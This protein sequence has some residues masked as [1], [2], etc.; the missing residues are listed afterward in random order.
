MNTGL[1]VLLGL[2]PAWA[3]A[4]LELLPDDQLQTVFSSEA[5]RARVVFRNSGP[6]PIEVC[7]RT[8][9]FQASSTTLMPLDEAQ[10]WKTIRLL[11]EQTV[12]EHITVTLPAVRARTL[13]HVQWLD[14]KNAVLGRTILAAYPNDL[15]KPLKG[16]A[17]EKRLGVLDMDEQLIPALKRAGVEFTDLRSGP[18]LDGFEGGVAIIF[19]KGVADLPA[20]I[21]ARAKR[22][23]SVVWILPTNRNATPLEPSAWAVHP[24]LGT[25]VMAQP[26][27]V[28]TFDQSPLAQLNLVRFVEWALNPDTLRLPD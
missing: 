8:R 21:T 11:E 6:R 25:V 3:A 13:F 20:R 14:E 26:F 12:I 24:G 7:L 10:P 22:G 23:L 17:R 15:L 4:Q 18:G 5:R 2:C 9:L 28:A 1:L 27:T 19:S 16:I